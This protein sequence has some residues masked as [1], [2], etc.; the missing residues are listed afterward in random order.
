[1]NAKWLNIHTMIFVCTWNVHRPIRRFAVWD[2]TIM[3]MVDPHTNKA[4]LSVHWHQHF[5]MD[6]DFSGT[7][8]LSSSDNFEAYLDAMGEWYYYILLRCLVNP[9]DWSMGNYD[10]DSSNILDT[11]MHPRSP[12]KVLSQVPQKWR[13]MTHGCDWERLLSVLIICRHKSKMAY[14]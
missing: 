13:F 9:C 8:V 14:M 11:E 10:R 2:F 5:D 3:A 6:V 7:W 12:G 4:P 1:M